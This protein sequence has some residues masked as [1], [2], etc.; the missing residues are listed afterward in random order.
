MASSEWKVASSKRPEDSYMK[1]KLEVCDSQ[2]E[3]G[4]STLSLSASI[5]ESVMIGITYQY[6]HSS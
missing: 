2:L 6:S 3:T 1:R 4:N 5:E